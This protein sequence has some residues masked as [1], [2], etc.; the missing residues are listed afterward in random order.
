[1]R[2]VL[3][4]IPLPWGDDSIPV[5]SY[6]LMIVLGFLLA[7]H[8]ANR[9]S[10]RRGMPDFI[11]DLG[12]VMLLSGLVGGRVFYY[13]ENWEEKY[14][15]ESFL[16]LFK[17]W[18]G[19]LVFYGG[20]FAGCV[21]GILYC[22][23]KKL[24]ILACMDMAAI[25]APIGMAFGRLGCFLNGCCFGTICDPASPIGLVFPTDSPAG[26]AQR[27]E[28]ILT[29]SASAT[30]PVHPIQLYQA[31]HDFLLAG[32]LLWY[33]RRDS[34]PRGAGMPLLFTLYGV[35]RFCLE[36][37][38]DDNPPVLLGL[39]ISQTLSIALVVTFGSIFLA[40][41]AFYPKR[42]NEIPGKLAKKI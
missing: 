10:R 32:I 25:G 2:P 17:I 6:G 3:F 22:W 34:A 26:E 36:G 12:L 29:H 8:V 42:L 13:I 33:L 7:A 18:K 23:K 24:P 28:G 41:L 5:H 40:L 39:T 27:L 4:R 14:A 15:G 16:E 31:A 1:M 30:L 9:E 19:G 21:G 20:A 37:L 11:Y 38:R 35:G